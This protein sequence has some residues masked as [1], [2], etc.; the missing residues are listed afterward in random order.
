M[1]NKLFKIFACG[2][3]LTLICTDVYGGDLAISWLKVT[4]KDD[5]TESGKI[6]IRELTSLQD[7]TFWSK[8]TKVDV[9]VVIENKG[10][11]PN[12]FIGITPELYY[13]VKP[14]NTKFPPMK[15][16]LRSLTNKPTWVWIRTLA[17][18]AIRELKPGETKK[19][20][21]TE[22]DIRNTYYATDYQVHA[23]AIRVFVKSKKG[24]DNNFSNNVKEWIV[25][26]GD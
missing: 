21:F 7:D 3:V 6:I 19:L 18:D 25:S 5:V 1:I 16:E 4:Y 9:E 13:L 17:S 26:Y 14:E 22:L 11:T 12:L 8:P 23:F 24:E 10:E 2:V 15:G 20:K